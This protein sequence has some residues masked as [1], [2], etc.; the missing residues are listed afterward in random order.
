MGQDPLRKCISC[1]LEAYDMEDAIER[2][3]K[4]KGSK[5]G[6][7]NLCIKCCVERNAAHPKQK[8]WKTDHQTKKRYGVSAEEY[9]K[10]MAESSSCVLCDSQENLCYDHCHTTM[11][12]RGVLCRKCNTA[13]GLFKDNPEL[14]R[15]AAEYVEQQR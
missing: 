5:Y 10:A 3:V 7:R 4:N 1:G 12:F 13:L 11:K 14:L 9:K 15:K 6:L 8:E 2:F